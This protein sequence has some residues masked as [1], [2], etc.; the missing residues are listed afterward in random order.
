MRHK[1]HTHSFNRRGGPRKALIKGL[2]ISLV[3]HERVRTTHAKAR[4][5]RR[6]VERAVTLGKKGDLNSR[7]ILAGRFGNDEAAEKLIKV[8]GPRFK[9]RAGGYTRI[10]KLSDRPGDMA[11]MA[12]I[13]FVDYKPS[14]AAETV[15]KGDA[16]A[17]ARERVKTRANA[18]KRKNI[19][20]MKSSSRRANRR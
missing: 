7:R 13:E 1:I 9:S 3:E 4:E 12:F 5:L 14:A 6:H 19:R 18:K 2:V 16:T 20:Q 10:L 11:P 17:V 15:V 8:I